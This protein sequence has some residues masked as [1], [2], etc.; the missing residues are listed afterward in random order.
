MI[1]ITVGTQAPFDRLLETIDKI[2]GIYPAKEFVAQTLMSEYKPINLKT[3]D[4]LEPKEFD[5]LFDSAEL[6]VSHA[7]IGTIISALAKHK[8]LLIM[9][10]KAEFGEHRNDHQLMTATRFQTL[11]YVHVA[12]DEQEMS[13]ML[14]KILDT[15]SAK[16]LHKMGHYASVELINSLKQFIANFETPRVNPNK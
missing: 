16:V 9:P 15:E 11:K 14:N 13:A 7:G 3:V 2:A 12:Q 10:R 4:F 5:T 8:P 6:I 1:F